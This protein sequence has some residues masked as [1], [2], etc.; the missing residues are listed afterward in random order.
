MQLSPTT[1]EGAKISL[2]GAVAGAALDALDE[3]PDRLGGHLGDGML[4]P[5]EPRADAAMAGD[6]V[7]GGDGDVGRAAQAEIAERPHDAERHHAVGDVERGRA[8]VARK[9]VARHRVGELLAKLAGTQVVRVGGEA[10][11]RHRVAHALRAGR[12]RWRCSSGR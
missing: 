12:G 8:V 9:Q 10:A 5:G 3:E 2:R 1:S 6:G 11:R 7:G 4:G